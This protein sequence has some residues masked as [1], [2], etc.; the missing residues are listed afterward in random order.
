M[1]TKIKYC[2]GYKNNAGVNKCE[3]RME[4]KLY[5]NFLRAEYD[6]RMNNSFKE[7]LLN[8]PFDDTDKKKTTCKH[9][10]KRKD[11]DSGINPIN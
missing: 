7:N 5:S 9:F 11:G 8:A 3:M 4:C 6:I 1:E 10:V 2:N